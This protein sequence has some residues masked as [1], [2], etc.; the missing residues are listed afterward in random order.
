MRRCGRTAVPGAERS[1]APARALGIAIQGA[2]RAAAVSEAS[3]PAPALRRALPPG[4]TRP[5]P[6]SLQLTWSRRHKSSPRGMEAAVAAAAQ[7]ARGG[8]SP[9]F[10]LPST[11][12]LSP[13]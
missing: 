1:R 3:P 2:E 13:P 5:P 4:T 6:A 11:H 9:F 7:L 10:R 12:T 8:N